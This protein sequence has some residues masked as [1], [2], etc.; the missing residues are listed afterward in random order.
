MITVAAG[1]SWD[2]N[3]IF[4][5]LERNRPGLPVLSS[6]SCILPP[7]IVLTVAPY[8]LSAPAVA[9]AR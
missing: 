2:I 7:Q 9:K 1:Y 8:Q 5:R 4:R 3:D 6:L